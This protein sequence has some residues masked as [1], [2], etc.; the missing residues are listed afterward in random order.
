MALSKVTVNGLRV[1]DKFDLGSRFFSIPAGASVISPS[2]VGVATPV[3]SYNAR[4][5]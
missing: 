5:L 4:W 2:P 1:M 3:V